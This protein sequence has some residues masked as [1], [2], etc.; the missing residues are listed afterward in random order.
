V[1]STN[2]GAERRTDDAYMTPPWCVRRLQD[3]WRVPTRGVLVEPAVGSGNI[4]NTLVTDLHWVVYDIRAYNVEALQSSV[5]DFL[6]LTTRHDTVS[7]VVTNPP[8]SLAEEFVRH[9]R[10]LYPNAELVFLLR[11]SFL[12]SASRLPLWRDLGTPDIYVLP[13]RPSFTGYGTDS[14]D[15]AWFVWPADALRS[16]GGLKILAET[17]A[18]ERKAP[19]LPPPQETAPA[20]WL[21]KVSEGLVTP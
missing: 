3:V 9:S 14:V 15:Y 2:R 13:N 20:K 4:V 21:R 7:A 16:D 10:K 11:I 18:S 1:S 12:A 5:L 6:S 17:P 8:F 19:A